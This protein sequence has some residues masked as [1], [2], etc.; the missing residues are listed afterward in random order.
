MSGTKLQHLIDVTGPVCVKYEQAV[1][2]NAT[3]GRF[4]SLIQ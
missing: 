2:A 3:E 1:L 4:A